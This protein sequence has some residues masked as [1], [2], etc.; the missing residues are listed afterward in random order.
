MAKDDASQQTT[1]EQHATGGRLQMLL[2]QHLQ[3]IQ[4]EEQDHI[5]RIADLEC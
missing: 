1:G 3:A 4:K 2:G 5:A